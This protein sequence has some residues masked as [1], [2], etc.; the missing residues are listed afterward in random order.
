MLKLISTETTKGNPAVIQGRIFV[1]FLKWTSRD[2]AKK[3]LKDSWRNLR[4]Y[5]WQNLEQICEGI[6]KVF[7]AEIL[8]EFLKESHIEP[9]KEPQRKLLKQ[10][11]INP[12]NS[13]ILAETP[14]STLWR[15][16]EGNP[17]RTPVPEGPPAGGPP[18]SYKC[19]ALTHILFDSFDYFENLPTISSKMFNAFLRNFCWFL[20]FSSFFF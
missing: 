9:L 16:R 14:R 8:V 6:H 4:M 3:V 12:W 1:W 7:P 11:I 5:S 10:F 19:C 17:D 15:K 18:T 13:R 2:S 20:R